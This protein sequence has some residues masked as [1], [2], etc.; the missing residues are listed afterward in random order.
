MPGDLKEKARNFPKASWFT[1]PSSASTFRI[2][3]GFVD[4]ESSSDDRSDR[5]HAEQIATR[6]KSNRQEKQHGQKKDKE[7]SKK[8]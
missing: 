4:C 8:I 1:S 5:N 3:S 6:K 7:S 2:A